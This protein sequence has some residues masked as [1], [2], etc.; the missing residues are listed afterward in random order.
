M[1][2][3]ST[4]ARVANRRASKLKKAKW[5]PMIAPTI[6]APSEVRRGRVVQLG[7]LRVDLGRNEA[8]SYA[9]TDG[10]RYRMDLISPWDRELPRIIIWDVA[11]NVVET[12]NPWTRA[13]RI[14][15]L[16]SEAVG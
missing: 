11:G 10:R 13:D 12:V 16:L 7:P 14:A 4:R 6:K 15:E 2:N 1:A 5:L 8:H 3:V 9:S